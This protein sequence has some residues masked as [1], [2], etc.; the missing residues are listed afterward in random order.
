MNNVWLRAPWRRRNLKAKILLMIEHFR[1][2][3]I[4]VVGTS[5]AALAQT[6]SH[7]PL[8]IDV[9][10]ERP[11]IELRDQAQSLNVDLPV[12]NEIT[13]PL[14]IAEIQVDVYDAGHQLVMRKSINTDA[15]APSITVIG[16]QTLAPGETLDIFNPFSEFD[17]ALPLAEL[18]YSFCLR[19]EANEEEAEKNRHRLVDDCDFRQPFTVVP[20]SYDNKTALVLPV[21][22]KVFIWEGHDFYAHHLRVPLGQAKIRDMGLTANSNEFASD[23]VYLDEQGRQYHD[24]P[25]RL[26]NWYGYGKAIYAPGPGVVLAMANDIAENWFE[27]VKATRIGYPKLPAGKDPKDIGNFVLIDHQN[28]EYSLLIHMKPG[29]TKVKAGDRVRPGQQIGQIGFAGDSIFPHLHY[30]LMDGPQVFKAWGLPAYFQNF[31][32]V[33]G[34]KTIRIERGPVNSGDFIESDV[35]YVG[36]R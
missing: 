20:R 18:R 26:E 25:R 9:A 1:W 27:D 29:S 15:L 6:P 8:A 34:S 16:K 12:S 21:R 10:P 11:I 19:R 23:F 33:L 24:D 28:G 17:A 31:H 3:W 5:C 4:L 7:G 30:C 32:R 35:T 2:R 36:A 22:G 14:R 13:V